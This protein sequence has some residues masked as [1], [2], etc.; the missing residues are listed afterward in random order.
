MINS[1]IINKP[2]TILKSMTIFKDYKIVQ[3]NPRHIQFK[4]IKSI[5][6]L[7]LSKSFY[8]NQKSKVQLLQILVFQTSWNSFE[9]L[10]QGQI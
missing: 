2:R 5:K 3:D 6:S 9:F 8:D 1:D 7:R 10:V 4:S